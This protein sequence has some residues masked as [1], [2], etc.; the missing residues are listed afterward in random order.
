MRR[1]FFEELV[2]SRL[3]F[4]LVTVYSYRKRVKLRHKI[5]HNRYSQN[6]L[7]V[8]VKLVI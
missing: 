1:V 8:K 6:V 3:S 2:F 7:I 4:D 5:V